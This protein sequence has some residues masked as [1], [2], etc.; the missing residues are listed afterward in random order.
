MPHPQEVI[1]YAAT[2]RLMLADAWE[3]IKENKRLK[4]GNFTPEELQN[5]CH[6]I[7]GGTRGEFEAGCKVYTD[8]LFGPGESKEI[9]DLKK[10]ILEL[11]D[12]IRR[13]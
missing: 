3:L 12:W 11:R 4:E 8:S 5:L 13:H 6:N 10:E 2:L 9:T 7:K 1:V